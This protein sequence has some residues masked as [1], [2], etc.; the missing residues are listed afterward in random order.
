[1]GSLAASNPAPTTPP[2]SSPPPLPLSAT[3]N[4]INSHP[5]PAHLS[6]AAHTL[7]LQIA[8]NLR[9]QHLW[10]DLRLH[11]VIPTSPQN[12]QDVVVPLLLLSGLPPN[13]LYIHPDEQIEFLQLQKKLGG[14]G[15]G[16]KTVVGEK[17]K[18]GLEPEREWVLPS[19]LTEKWTL[20]RFARVFDSIGG[21]VPAGDDGGEEEEVIFGDGG[22]GRGGDGD[23]DGGGRGEDNK[24]R[25]TQPKR[26]LLATVDDDGT[27]VYYIVHDGLV[28][29]RQN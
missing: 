9:F 12:P 11:T 15:G 1:M 5:T 4:L 17:K 28:K 19:H 21:V 22:K 3:T 23:D 25:V 16:G 18:E 14:G 26:L 10:T 20:G 2:P 24:W 29:P 27:T 7:A 8:H 13:R 6:H